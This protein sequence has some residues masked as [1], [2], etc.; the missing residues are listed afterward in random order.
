MYSRA[1]IPRGAHWQFSRLGSPVTQYRVHEAREEQTRRATKEDE[2]S[3]F[4]VLRVILR[5]FVNSAFESK[6]RCAKN[7][8]DRAHQTHFKPN[9]T[10]CT[11]VFDA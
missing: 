1:E 6:S 7:G 10:Q 11:R 4:A 3:S 5:A 9:Q 2:G 8:F